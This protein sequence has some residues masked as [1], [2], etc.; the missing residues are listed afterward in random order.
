MRTEGARTSSRP[1]TWGTYVFGVAASRVRASRIIWSRSPKV[2]APV[3]HT[4]AQAGAFPAAI[5]SGH[6]MHFCT[7]GTARSHWYFGT[8]KGHAMMQYRQ[9][10]QRLAS[11]KTGPFRS[12]RNARTG[13]TETQVGDSQWLHMRRMKAV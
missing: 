7:M 5:R 11:D 12:F 2:V 3:G 8:P 10:M 4:L 6:M 13:Q 1:Y 9:P